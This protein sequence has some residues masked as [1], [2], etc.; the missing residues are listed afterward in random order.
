MVAENKEDRGSVRSHFLGQVYQQETYLFSVKETR[1]HI[2]VSRFFTTLS[3]TAAQIKLDI[4]STPSSHRSGRRSGTRHSAR[5]PLL[6][7]MEARPR[8]R[9]PA[10]S[11]NECGN[12]SQ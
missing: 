12:G 5:G 9:Y 6:P 7:R 10:P 11:G 8:D 2:V 4:L 3:F 1:H